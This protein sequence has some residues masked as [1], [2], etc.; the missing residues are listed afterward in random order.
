MPWLLTT[1]DKMSRRSNF[2][3]WII[4]LCIPRD[5][6]NPNC[7]GI[8]INVRKFISN[9]I[10]S[11]AFIE[12]NEKKHI[13]LLRWVEKW[14]NRGWSLISSILN[15]NNRISF[16]CIVET[17]FLKAWWV[18]WIYRKDFYAI[19]NHRGVPWLFWKTIFD[20]K[21]RSIVNGSRPISAFTERFAFSIYNTHVWNVHVNE[22][23]EL[24][25]SK[26][27]ILFDF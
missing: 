24:F 18:F 14:K 22:T 27:R 10:G 12:N 23:R 3:S 5:F 6:S 26:A 1:F 4:H 11:E 15:A 19:Q 16:N 25:K 7:I 9:S 17:S 21:K 20:R 2:P 8:K 13:S